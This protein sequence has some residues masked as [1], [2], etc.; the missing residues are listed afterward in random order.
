MD[1]PLRDIFRSRKFM[2]V[3]GYSTVHLREPQLFS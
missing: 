1:E 2:E 3:E